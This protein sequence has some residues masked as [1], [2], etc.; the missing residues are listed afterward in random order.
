[1]MLDNIKVAR[2]AYRLYFQNAPFLSRVSCA[3]R[4]IRH[5]F[6]RITAP[7]SVMI[8]L[9]Y[10]CQ[11][12]CVHC[13]MELFRSGGEKELSTEEVKSVITAAH[14]LGAVEITLFG[15]EP[16]LRNDLEEI[17]T[18]ARKLRMLP[19][20][21]TNGLLLSPGKIEKLK[22]AGLTVL[23]VSLDSPDAG[24]HD[25]L[26]GVEGCFEKAVAALK[27]ARKRG[28]ARVISTYATRENIQSGDLKR[29]IRRGRELGVTA[30]RIIDTTL[31]GCFLN[32][33][34]RELAAP[35][36]EEL[37]RLL[38]PGFVFLENLASARALT[39]PVC[40]A[41][42]RRYVYIS[43]HGDLQPCC[44]VPLSFGNIR[45][46]PLGEILQRLWESHLMNYDSHRCLMNNPQFRR[47]YLEKI[48]KAKTLPI[49][50][51]DENT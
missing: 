25:R 15:G 39:H 19:S 2:L 50:F 3:F 46:T 4:L 36:R 20:L 40:S 38:E 41:L 42:A 8:G 35:E 17:I 32:A 10:R 31:S 14:A 9:T 51:G 48:G 29:L 49:V 23:K 12:R 21:D 37:A 34:P 11:C 22:A 24:E 44:F 26:R 18:H 13:G 6:S 43:P 30:V 28:L 33:P 1:M 47:D 16:L 45:R 7:I 27:E 5:R